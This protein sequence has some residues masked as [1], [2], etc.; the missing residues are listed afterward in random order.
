MQHL[1]ELLKIV[2]G[3][4]TADQPKVVAYTRQL[5]QKL[6]EQGDGNAAE[7]LE[8]LITNG[9]G[10]TYLG[11]AGALPDRIPVDNESRLGLADEEFFEVS[12]VEIFL[13]PQLE[14]TLAE[15]VTSIKSAS[16]LVAN[17]VDVDA[18]LL[19]YGP[20]GCGKTELARYLSAELGLPLLTARTDALISSFLGS[21]AKNIRL[22]FEHAMARPCVL[23]L[24]ELDALAKLRDDQHELGELKRVVISLL[25]NIDALDDRTIVV[26]ATNHPHLLDPAVWRRFAYKLNL[27]PPS[28][29]IRKQLFSRFLSDLATD[30]QLSL[31]AE[32]ADQLTG[33]D[34]RRVTQNVKRATV[35]ADAKSCDE[36]DTLRRILRQKGIVWSPKNTPEL[37][38]CVRQVRELNPAIYTYR[39]LAGLFG[40]S[41][42]YISKL[43]TE[44]ENRWTV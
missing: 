13:E 35:L 44:E 19:L 8:R 12:D 30:G 40:V 41:K 25:Q 26:A 32:A 43:L 27:H 3:A 34:I 24:D 18:S 11:P 5:A 23:F 17:G 16:K 42:S 6:R 21:T 37:A 29:E 22:L 1:L 39:R 15:F 10:R 14:A 28:T 20:P 2:D 38:H 31:F 7:K 36:V 33:A 4:L 9:N